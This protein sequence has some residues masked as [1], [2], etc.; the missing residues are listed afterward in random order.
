MTDLKTGMEIE[1]RFNQLEAVVFDLQNRL[2]KVEGK[3]S[4]D[5]V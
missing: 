3:K 5:D 2:N 4:D 1:A